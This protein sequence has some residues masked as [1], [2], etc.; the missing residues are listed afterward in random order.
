MYYSPSNIFKFIEQF[1]HQIMTV[2]D[3]SPLNK[4]ET[5]EFVLI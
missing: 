3:Y 5:H 1:E 4:T 2:V